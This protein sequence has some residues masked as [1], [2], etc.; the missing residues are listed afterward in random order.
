MLWYGDRERHSNTNGTSSVC[1]PCAM[2]QLSL[3]N[4]GSVSRT[5]RNVK[6]PAPNGCKTE[7]L[8]KWLEEY[9]VEI[10]I[11]ESRN[12]N[13]IRLSTAE[14]HQCAKEMSSKLNFVEGATSLRVGRIP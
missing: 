3:T 2:G 11:P 4:L 9:K 8:G 10:F 7:P 6:G 5:N 13:I 12:A 14:A 1:L